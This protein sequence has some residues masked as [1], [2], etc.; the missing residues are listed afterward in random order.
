[1]AGNWILVGQWRFEQNPKAVF[2]SDFVRL[3]MIQRRLQKAA[4]SFLR[5]N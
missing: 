2:C 5:K 4:T 3:E 1:M